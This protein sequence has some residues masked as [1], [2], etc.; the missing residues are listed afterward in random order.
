MCTKSNLL[1]FHASFTKLYNYV[2][3][4]KMNA[5]DNSNLQQNKF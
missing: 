2:D 5:T 3:D 1:E 4:S